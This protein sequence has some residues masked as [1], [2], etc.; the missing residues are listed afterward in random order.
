MGGQNVRVDARFSVVHLPH[1]A[2]V[3]MNA[4]HAGGP[5]PSSPPRP[6]SVGVCGSGVRGLT[7]QG[8]WEKWV[9]SFSPS[10]D[11]E[12]SLANVVKQ[13]GYP[14]L[15]G[16]VGRCALSLEALWMTKWA[17]PCAIRSA[18]C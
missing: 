9:K 14:G 15:A 8:V 6:C 3:L 11:T 1:N 10:N 13:V 5:L 4:L 12:T 7:V 16:S 17:A 18:S 2:F